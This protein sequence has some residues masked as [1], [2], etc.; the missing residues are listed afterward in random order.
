MLGISETED[1]LGLE[2]RT[3]RQHFADAQLMV[4]FSSDKICKMCQLLEGL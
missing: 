3:L 2:E 1:I 4:Q